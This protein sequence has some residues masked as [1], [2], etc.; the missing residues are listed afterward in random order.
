MDLFYNFVMDLFYNFVMDLFYNFVMD[1]FYNLRVNLYI[2]LCLGN[3]L[4]IF[5]SHHPFKQ[6]LMFLSFNSSKCL[7]VSMLLNLN[8]I[9]TWIFNMTSS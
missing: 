2:K 8:K 1:L 4:R 3:E 7:P 6:L 9:K 5:F